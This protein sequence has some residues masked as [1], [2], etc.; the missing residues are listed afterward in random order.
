MSDLQDAETQITS[1]RR[2]AASL[3]CSGRGNGQWVAAEWRRT[4]SATGSRLTHFLQ[5]GF[6]DLGETVLILALAMTS[7]LPLALAACWVAW[8]ADRRNR[9]KPHDKPKTKTSLRR[10]AHDR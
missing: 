10:A 2:P 4:T 6:M 7:C 1:G 3:A 9:S 5:G 8:M